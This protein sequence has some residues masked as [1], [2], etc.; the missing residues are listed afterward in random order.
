MSKRIY[1][2]NLVVIFVVILSITG[3]P[4]Y[5]ADGD[6][7]EP[8]VIEAMPEP[9]LVFPGLERLDNDPTDPDIFPT[10]PTQMNDPRLIGAVPD[11]SGA[12]GHTHYLQAVNKMVALYRKNGVLI[13]SATFDEFWAEATTGTLCDSGEADT[14]HG[15]PFVVY[16]HLSGRWVVSDVAYTD[17]DNGPYYICVAVSNS[18]PAPLTPG[19]YFNSTYWYFYAISTNQG[20]FHYYPDSPKLGFWP[21][22]YYLA[23]DMIDVSNNGFNR[24]PRGVKVWALNRE[25]LIAGLV[26][27][28]RSIDFYLSEQLG[29]EHL[30][31]SNLLGLPPATGTPNYFASIQ[32]GK[33]HI[34][35]F[36]AD[37][38]ELSP[39]TFGTSP[40]HRPNYSLETDTQSIWAIGYQVRQQRR[41]ERL[42]VHG[43]RLMSPLQ[44]RIL[45]GIPSL[46]VSHAVEN[47]SAS[48]V[49]WYEIR[50]DAE[51]TPFFYQ[52][53][54]Y[55]PGT[56]V[57]RWNSSLA[58][59][60]VGDMAVGYNVSSSSMHPAIR[61]AGRL[62]SDPVG[63]LSQGEA[64]F[65]RGGFPTYNG[66][67]YDGDGLYDG[68]WGRQSQMSIDPLDECIF[69]YTNMYY[70]DQSGGTDWRTAIGWFSFPQCKGGITKRISL[71]TNDTQGNF[72]SGLDF[73]MYSVGISNNGR[74]V[75][76]SSEAT[77]LVDGDTNG[78]RDV[79][80]R[81]RDTD[82]DG[83]FDEPG[84]VK[85]TRI[86]RAYSG[87]QANGDSWEVS[88]SGNGRYIAFSSDASNLVPGDTNGARDVFVFDRST[89]ETRRVSVVDKTS[90]GN[91]N[92]QS[93]QPFI[94][95]SGDFVVFRSYASNLVSGDTN[96]V[97]DIFLR[98]LVHERTYR[99]SVPDPSV[100]AAQA[101]GESATPSISNNGQYIAFASKAT[102]LT[103][104]NVNGSIMDVFLRDWINDTTTLVSFTA[105]GD[106]GDSYTPYISGNSRYVAFASRAYSL[107]AVEVAGD[108]DADIFVYD[109]VQ[110]DISRVSVNFFGDEAQ[111][112]DSYSPSITSDGR[113]IAFASEA[114][115]L[116][117][118]VPDLNG[119]RDIYVHDRTLGLSSI[120]DFGLTQRI[121]LSYTGGE[122]NEWS[123]VPVIA[124]LGRHV[125]YVS[126]ATNLVNNDTNNAWD[127]F[128]FDSERSVPNFLSIPANI[129]G[130]AGETVSVPIIFS[131]NGMDIDTT[132]FSIDFDQKCLSFNSGMA[133]AVTFHVPP[134]FVTTWS[135]N[136]GDKDGEIDI[137][138]YDQTEPRSII[139]DGTLV[140]IKLTV[141]ATC[142]PES[143]GAARVGF[144]VD[145]P[146]SFGSYGQSIPGYTTDGFIRLLPGKLGDCNGDDLV[147]AGDLS[148]LVLEI[149]DGDDMLPGNTPGGTFPGDPVGCNPNQDAVVDA[150]DLSCTVL[151]IWG[152]G[153]AACAGDGTQLDQVEDNTDGEV[154]LAIPEKFPAFPGEL[155]TVPLRFEP[156]GNQVS[157]LAF[158]VDFDS[159][160][161]AFLERDQDADGLPDGIH[162]NLP[163]GFL[164]SA[165]F[166]P[167]DTNGEIDVVIYRPGLT[168]AALPASDFM[169]LTFEVK[170][171]SPAEAEVASAREPWASFGSLNGSSLPALIKNGSVQV[172][173]PTTTFIFLP[174]T[175]YER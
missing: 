141:K 93:D 157:S 137:S 15:Q 80:L 65:R 63:K 86:S 131:Q 123:F 83:L 165:T 138:I 130:G 67:Q 132:T 127:V 53:G 27:T 118:N 44:Y 24:T 74:Y 56:T 13:D 114:N 135:Y 2:S 158:S 23:A 70:D 98:D 37:W 49:R 101:N 104:T 33:F 90:N 1:W 159:S 64:V 88:I 136:S 161:L 76:F 84:L 150:G 12:A 43:E 59:D 9:T 69:W 133:G 106:A 119:R 78:H 134:D 139:P 66:S 171:D 47:D 147:D 25:D 54:T 109:R 112:G 173:D 72:S 110:T 149:F 30:V 50:R 94:S 75:A 140:T 92:A 166:D 79:F 156:G 120:Y 17:I 113:F 87:G 142:R 116:D 121:S 58:V 3:V 51:G 52:Q 155:V 4:A 168:G 38:N 170:V 126:E 81:D 164:A 6:E 160:R 46:W 40:S 163:E 26:S 39:S 174:V 22:G 91:A 7:V 73:E 16:D 18:L 82:K 103:T 85:T 97:A 55:A 100:G 102:N 124:P 105:G 8:E 32:P 172:Y 28:F 42:D 5:A 143:T 77:N 10:I 167:D 146:A 115:N 36:Y 57:Y 68:P 19:A 108:Y 35:E 144:S 152:N 11:V 29:Y 20:N 62:K 89:G 48:G 21:D 145:P 61:Y 99:I 60:R 162:F 31:P 153:T 95:S 34:W 169:S 41:S 45:D 128:A 129:P 148:A 14:H 125:A 71:H 117:V 154:L 111:N 151:I 122:P 175:V 96:T 107:D